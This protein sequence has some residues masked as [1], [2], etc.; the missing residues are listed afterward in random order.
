MKTA[1]GTLLHNNW[2][3]KPYHQ[4]PPQ[5][6]TEARIDAVFSGDLEGSAKTRFLMQYPTDSTCHY[7]GYM[8]VD[9]VLDGK[10]GTFVIYEVGDW[11]D[12]I[13][14]SRWEIVK[15][16]GTGALTGIVGTGKY[17]A[18]HDKSVHYEISY[19]LR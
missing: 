3:E 14:S 10:A 5:K 18:A 8:L 12:G 11:A 13:A 6:S 2:D 15:T 9:G 7:A 19:E 1:K 4:A 17:A 16:S